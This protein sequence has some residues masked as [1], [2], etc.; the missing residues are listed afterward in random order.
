MP[1]TSVIATADTTISAENLQAAAAAGRV[2]FHT[3]RANGSLRRM[4]Y[5]RPGTKERTEAEQVAAS[6]TAGVH[7]KAI[8]ASLHASVPTIR[9]MINN[10]ELSR[11]VEAGDTAYLMGLVDASKPEEPTAD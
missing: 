9:R 7:M 11:H 4:A 3:R 5:L 2:V 6:R 1:R 8:S 10:L